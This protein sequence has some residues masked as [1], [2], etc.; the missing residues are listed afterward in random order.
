MPT[1]MWKKSS[2]ERKYKKEKARDK[3]SKNNRKDRQR[4]IKV[5]NGEKLQ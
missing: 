1:I 3:E 4:W 5:D 2:C